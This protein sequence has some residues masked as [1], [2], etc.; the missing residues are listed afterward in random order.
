MNF[1]NLCEAMALFMWLWVDVGRD[2]RWYQECLGMQI[3]R[4]RD[5]PEEKYMNVFMGFGPEDNHFAAELTYSKCRISPLYV[6][7]CYLMVKNTIT[8][9]NYGHIPLA[10]T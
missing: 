3:L 4:K 8:K 7:S 9:W 2:C 5:V 6:F 10:E 1:W